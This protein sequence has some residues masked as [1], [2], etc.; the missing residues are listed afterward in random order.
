M[1]KPFYMHRRNG[2]FYV[3]FRDPATDEILPAR[4]SGLRNKTAAERWANQELDRILRFARY[5]D[6]A[7]GDWA[8]KF[9]QEKGCPHLTRVLAEGGRCSDKTKA[10]NRSFIEYY[11]LPD[12]VCLMRVSEVEKPDALGF[13]NRLLDDVGP[14][15][16][17]QLV[18]GLFHTMCLEAV[19]YGLSDVDACFGLKRISYDVNQRIALT[20]EQVVKIL[21]PSLWENLTHWRMTVCSV[22]TGMRAGEVRALQWDDLDP[23]S[24]LISV[25]HNLPGEV[26]AE[27]MTSPKWGKER[28][29]PYPGVLKKILEPLRSDGFVFSW[30]GMPCGYHRWLDSFSKVAVAAG[31]EGATLHSLRHSLHTL[32]RGNGI[33]ADILR[34]SFGWSS[35]D[36][37]EGYTHRELYDLGPQRLMIDSLFKG[38]EVPDV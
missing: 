31:A 8:K 38:L 3:E 7:F 20:L 9:Y 36:T 12:P 18:F 23:L 5:G 14:C 25:Q 26:G 21:A 32:L 34:A 4:S 19:I 2:I 29:L 24:G 27:R 16:T 17:S 37:Q 15:R 6:M 35:A 1:R 22:L 11:V 30:Q 28:V 10:Q 13:R 33:P